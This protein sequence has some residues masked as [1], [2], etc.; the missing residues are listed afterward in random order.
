MNTQIFHLKKYDLKDHW[1]SQK[2]IQPNPSPNGLSVD[3]SLP[4]CVYF[5]FCHS[6]S[7][8]LFPSLSLTFFLYSSLPPSFAPGKHLCSFLKVTWGHFYEAWFSDLLIKLQPWLILTLT[9]VL[10]DNFLSLFNVNFDKG[11]YQL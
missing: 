6:P 8:S 1:R 4:H 10:M 9:Y 3:A 2:F 11:Y 5:S 7:R